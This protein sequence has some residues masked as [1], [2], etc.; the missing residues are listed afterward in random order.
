MLTNPHVVI[1]QEN[2]LRRQA[3]ILRMVAIGKVNQL[4]RQLNSMTRHRLFLRL[5]Q[6][7]FALGYLRLAWRNR[8][9]CKHQI[10]FLRN[11]SQEAS[12]IHCCELESARACV[13]FIWRIQTVLFYRSKT[14]QA[15][16]TLSQFFLCFFLDFTRFRL[17]L[18]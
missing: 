5:I 14:S 9:L 11:R 6:N 8:S 10:L 7:K 13:L 2:H 4:S 15:Y 18:E 1:H 17:S 3:S 16:S 12:Q